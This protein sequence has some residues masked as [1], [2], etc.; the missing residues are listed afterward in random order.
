[1]NGSQLYATDQEITNL[2]NTV[3]SAG[4]GPVQYSN[5]ATP[6]TPNG[7]AASQDLTLVGAAAGP[8]RLHNV[9]AGVAL[10][11]AADVGQLDAAVGALGSAINKLGSN[12]ASD[13]GG[14]ATYD[15]TTGTLSSP[16]YTVGN[17][18]YNNAGA[19]IEAINTTLSQIGGNRLVQQRGGSHGQI[20]IGGATGGTVLNIAGTD[21]DRRISGVAPGAV[22]ANSTQAVNG[23]QLYQVENELNQSLGVN[24]ARNSYGAAASAMA[25]SGMPQTYE[26]GRSMVAL[27]V[28]AT[29]GQ[30]ALALG[31][32]R[33]TDNGRWVMKLNGSVSTT[34]KAGV[35][36]GVG[37]QW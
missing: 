27:G 5:A 12:T 14:G 31:V 15:A 26:A 25:Q 33:I 20:T 13:L 9:A 32:S 18:T 36:G 17:S 30:S 8:V 34:D 16:S 7:G 23:A 11:D 3:N 24:V 4:V 35:G 28:G 21:G 6:T 29:G 2:A 19:A 1:M 10:T 37:F 22:T